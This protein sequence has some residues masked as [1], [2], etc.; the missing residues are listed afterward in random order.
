MNYPEML[1][2]IRTDMHRDIVQEATVKTFSIHDGEPAELTL[3]IPFGMDTEDL[4]IIGVD[5]STGD[6]ISEDV[7]GNRNTVRYQHLSIEELAIIH[8]AI[9]EVKDYSIN[10]LV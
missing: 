7:N 10:H 1:I 6:L 3:R 5:C 8:L 4:Y 2:K 9:V